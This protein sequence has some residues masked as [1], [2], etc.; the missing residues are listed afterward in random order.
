[1]KIYG[2]KLRKGKGNREKNTLKKRV[3][4]P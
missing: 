2:K 1:M 3:K 4:N